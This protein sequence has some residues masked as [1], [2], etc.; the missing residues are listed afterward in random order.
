M[1]PMLFSFEIKCLNKINVKLIGLKGADYILLWF[2]LKN[3]FRHFPAKWHLYH[4]NANRSFPNE[5]KK[6]KK[7]E[8]FD[9]F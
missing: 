5:K 9:V 3:A 2:P 8:V 6:E 1:I 7:T 4:L